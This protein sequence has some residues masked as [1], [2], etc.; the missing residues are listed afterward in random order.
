MQ[1]ALTILVLLAMLGTLGVLAAGLIGMARGQSGE[2]SNRLMRY[3]IALQFVA[4]ILFA[5]LMFLLKG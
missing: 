3:R 4:L 5:L 2:S 1:T